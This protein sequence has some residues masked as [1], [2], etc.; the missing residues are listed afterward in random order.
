MHDRYPFNSNN[1]LFCSGIMPLFYQIYRD[2]FAFS[3]NV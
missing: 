3:N 2:V 1:A